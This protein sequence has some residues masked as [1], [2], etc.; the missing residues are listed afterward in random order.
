ML[1]RLLLRSAFLFLNILILSSAGIGRISSCS[2]DH[3]KDSNRRR[4]GSSPSPGAGGFHLDLHHVHGRCSPFNG[5]NTPPLNLS[6]L[7]VGDDNRVRSML[8]RTGG[9][10]TGAISTT[11]VATDAGVRS[12]L[13]SGVVIGVGNYIVEVQL[14][15]PPTSF[16][17]VVDTGSSFNWLQCKPCSVSCHYQI[18][19]IFDPK[20]S[21]THSHIHCDSRV[22]SYAQVA[23]LSTVSCNA[24]V[25]TTPCKY[26]AEY[27]DGSFSSGYVSKDTLRIGGKTLPGF[28]FGCGQNNVGLYGASAGLIGLSRNKLSLLTQ[29]SSYYG[30]P[31]FSYCLPTSTGSGGYLS[32]GGAYNASDYIFTAMVPSSLDKSLYFMELIGITVS[33]SSILASSDEYTRNPTIIDSGT[34]ITRL[35]SNIYTPFREAIKSA[36]SGN[37]RALS[38]LSIF[39]T[40]FIGSYQSLEVP[41]VEMVLGGGS[42]IKLTPANVF[43]DIPRLGIT[44]LAFAG[45]SRITII[46]NLQ[47]QTFSV[48]YDVGKRVIGFSPGGCS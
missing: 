42:R 19:S 16:L 29:L 45:S 17:T 14:G 46:G 26:M 32:I 34:V 37:A 5:K 41:D 33:Q 22:C 13:V 10:S 27:G 47:H 24:S 28:V 3:R 38:P 39:D 23:T 30:R 2:V 43:Y 20:L 15:T 35:P 1:T 12:P 36:M 7:Q 25:S 11:A 8:Y 18:G 4:N 9:K 6:A 44:C 21:T 40:C 31:S 48:V